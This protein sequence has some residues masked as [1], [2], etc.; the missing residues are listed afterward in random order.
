MEQTTRLPTWTL[1]DRLRKARLAADVSASDMADLLGVHRNSISAYENDRT[2]PKVHSIVQWSNATGIPL[3]WLLKGEVHCE[4][5]NALRSR[6]FSENPL[7]SGPEQ[8]EL[9]A[10]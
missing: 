9:G 6:C 4:E 2:E 8:L 5:C 10:A 7:V 3:D 1:G